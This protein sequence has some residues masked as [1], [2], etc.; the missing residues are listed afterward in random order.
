MPGTLAVINT[1]SY[2]AAIDGLIKEFPEKVFSQSTTDSYSQS[3]QMLIRKRLDY[4]RG[5]RD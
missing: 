4:T 3:V 2:G 5:S 1:R